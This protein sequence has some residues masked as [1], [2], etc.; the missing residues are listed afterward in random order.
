MDYRQA[1][2]KYQGATQTVEEGGD[3]ALLILNDTH[4]K[5]SPF[6]S[7]N[8]FYSLSRFLSFCLLFHLSM[9]KYHSLMS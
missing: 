2:E 9:V 8:L 5:S 7:Y 3:H 6:Y 4:N 1:V